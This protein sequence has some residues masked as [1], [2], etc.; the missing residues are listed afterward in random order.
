MLQ[1]A[2]LGQYKA[3][4]EF[5]LRI[6]YGSIDSCTADYIANETIVNRY[7]TCLHAHNRSAMM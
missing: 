7:L 2:V 1:S 5:M 3:S 6:P 4:A